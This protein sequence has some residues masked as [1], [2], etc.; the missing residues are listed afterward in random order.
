MTTDVGGIREVVI[1]G[2]TGVIVPPENSRALVRGLERALA[3]SDEMGRRG[4][5]HCLRHFEISVVS[6]AWDALLDELEHRVPPRH[7]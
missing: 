7:P 6:D 4:R 1:D 2:R 3:A 5:E